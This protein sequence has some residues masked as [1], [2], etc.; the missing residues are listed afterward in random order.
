[1]KFSKRWALVVVLICNLSL[2]QEENAPLFGKGLFNLVGK[3]NS[4]S[5]KIGLRMQFLASTSWLELE[6]DE[7]A[8]S[9]LRFELDAADDPV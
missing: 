6:N 9:T 4:W 5:M 1:M 3:D 8:V 7:G 2:A